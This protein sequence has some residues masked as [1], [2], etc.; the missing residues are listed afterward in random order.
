[1]VY[2]YKKTIG[3]K[4]YYYLR[5]SLTKNGKQVTKDLAYLGSDPSKIKDKL[6][7]LPQIHQKNVRKTYKTIHKFLEINYYLGKIKEKK[8]KKNDYLSKSQLEQI[9]ACK[10]HW[11]TIFK[12]LDI[13]SQDELLNDFAINFAYNTTSLEGNTIT[14]KEVEHLFIEKKTPKDRSLR[15]IY[16]L[17]NTIGIFFNIIDS[18]SKK[19]SHRLIQKIHS[20]L[21]ENIDV[22]TGYRNKDIRVTK[23]RFSSSPF[24]YVKADMD[25]LLD[26]FESHKKLHPIV[27]ASLFH[28]KFE[29]IYPFFDGNGRTGR[30]LANIILLM[31]KYPPL[32][33]SKKMRTTYLNALSY[34][35]KTDLNSISSK[36]YLKLTNF[37]AKEFSETYWNIFL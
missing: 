16:D 2:I 28:H 4:E 32:I 29:K 7:K 18:R 25:L 36:E 1:M 26:W 35:D 22:R 5:A 3:G 9:E 10:F 12:K 13:N 6:T 8:L 21:M 14:L 27:L 24:Q 33:I 37:I 34:A 17:Q 11:N 30:M 31:N 19:L 20:D 15:E 23:S